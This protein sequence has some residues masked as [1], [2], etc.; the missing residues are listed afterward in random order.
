MG[1]RWVCGDRSA[2]GMGFKWTVWWS[3]E[4]VGVA[5]WCQFGGLVVLGCWLQCLFNAKKIY[6]NN[7]KKKK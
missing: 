6:N 3:V 5:G 2:S 4:D 1:F 7:N